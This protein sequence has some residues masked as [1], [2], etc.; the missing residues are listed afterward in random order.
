[1]R[2]KNKFEMLPDDTNPRKACPKP[3]KEIRFY[4]DWTLI[5]QVVKV[6]EEK[7]P[8]TPKQI[9]R[10][11]VERHQASDNVNSLNVTK[12]TINVLKQQ[13]TV[14]ID[15]SAIKITSTSTTETLIYLIDPKK[16]IWKSFKDIP[17]E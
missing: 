10:K 4:R 12:R 8:M 14:L 15:H 5:G 3:I 13:G 6:L 1:M 7:S 17:N 16:Y 9:H 11:L 2:T